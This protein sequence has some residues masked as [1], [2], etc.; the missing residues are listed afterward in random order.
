[1]TTMPTQLA[2]ETEEKGSPFSGGGPSSARRVIRTMRKSPAVL[3]SAGFIALIT[4]M[5]IAAPLLTHLSG[6]GPYEYDPSAVNADLGGIPNG[7]LGGIGPTHWF[8]VE[9]QSGRDIFARIAFG[10]QVSLL[11]SVS[12]TLLTTFIGVVLGTL[13]GFYGGWVDQVISRLMD[14]LMAFPSLIFMIA[15]L[16]ALPAGNRPFLLVVVLSVF[17]WPYMAR[18][19]RGQTMSLKNREF[20]EAAYAS[21]ASRVRIVFREVLPNL[22]G[23]II[24][25]ATLSVPGYIG[26]EAGLSFLG[27]GVTPPTASWGQMIASAVPWYATDPMYFFVPGLF[28]FLTVLS[29]TVFGDH[30]SKAIDTGEAR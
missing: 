10:A 9:P 17:G 1:M 13:A 29:F 24:V 14:F 28:L 19:V 21:G 2:V 3:F 26:T 6:W 12:A 20:V 22:T 23:T 4:I 15:L 18:V 16:S 27:V 5:A 11:I 30:L 7:P 8:G 25:M